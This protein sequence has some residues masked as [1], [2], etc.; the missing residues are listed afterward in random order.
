MAEHRCSAGNGGSSPFIRF[1]AG[2]A[3]LAE[4]HPS[5]LEVEG[6]RPFAR[7]SRNG[8]RQCRGNVTT[9][10]ETGRRIQTVLAGTRM[11]VSIPSE[12]PVA[13]IT[14]AP[15]RCHIGGGSSDIFQVREAAWKQT[16]DG[17]LRA[18]AEN[19]RGSGMRP[20]KWLGARPCQPCQRLPTRRRSRPSWSWEM[21]R[22]DPSI[23][24]RHWSISPRHPGNQ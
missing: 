10:A 14:Y 15:G 22:K 1:S 17:V 9:P 12:P 11:P 5:K 18:V 20:H 16:R 6:S 13:P 2:V 19:R 23:G 7:S 8:P 21:I 3:Q 24:R 4:R